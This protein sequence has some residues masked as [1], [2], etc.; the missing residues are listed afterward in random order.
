MGSNNAGEHCTLRS[1]MIYGPTVHQ[2]LLGVI[3]PETL[4]LLRNVTC[5]EEMMK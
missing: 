4:K 1:V 2:I 5:M 3:K